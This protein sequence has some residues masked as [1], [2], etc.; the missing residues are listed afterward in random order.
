MKSAYE[1]ARERLREEDPSDSTPLT[2]E[3]KQA[4]AGID[5]TY[6]AKIAEKEIFLKGKLAEA[7]ANR[8][9]EGI[10]QL[11]IQLRNE[12]ARLA[13]ERERKKNSIREQAS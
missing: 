6:Q 1:L 10:Q 2:E 12:K 5:S 3:Q 9:Y 13:E 7:S 4:L 11:K 8:D